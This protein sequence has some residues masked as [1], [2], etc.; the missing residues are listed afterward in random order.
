MYLSRDNG[1]NWSAVSLPAVAGK[2]LHWD[3]MKGGRGLLVFIDVQT[4]NQVTLA[5]T[6]DFGASWDLYSFPQSERLAV[7]PLAAFSNVC[8]VSDS[9]MLCTVQ[10]RLFGSSDRGRTFQPLNPPITPQ[11]LERFNLNSAWLV[12]SLSDKL[13]LT[14]DA[15]RTWSERTFPD[16]VHRVSVDAEG[17]TVVTGDGSPRS[18]FATSPGG[19]DFLP[20]LLPD[21]DYMVSIAPKQTTFVSIDETRFCLFVA[22]D[23]SGTQRVY[24]TTDGGTHW[25]WLSAD[26]H[27]MDAWPISEAEVLVIGA[28]ATLY[29]VRFP[30]DAPFTVTA[31]GH[32]TRDSLNILVAWTDPTA[33]AWMDAEIERAAGDSI[34]T[35][36]AFVTA[37][38]RFFLDRDPGV[39]DTLRYR[40]TLNSA[41]GSVRQ[42][43][44]GVRAGRG[45]YF[46]LLGLILP[47]EAKTLR[48]RHH[49]I[50]T[51]GPVVQ[52]DS[53]SEVRYA[54]SPPIDSTRWIRVHNIGKTVS[55]PSGTDEISQVRILEF[56]GED[57]RF[58][59]YYSGTASNFGYKGLDR[60]F[61]FRALNEDVIGVIQPPFPVL[62]P[63]ALLA[64]PES[65]TVRFVSSDVSIFGD[66]STFRITAVYGTG[67]TSVVGTTRSG[68]LTIHD[69][70][71]LLEQVSPVREPSR[72]INIRIVANHP[73]PFVASTIIR[74]FLPAASQVRLSVHDQLGREIAVPVDEL[75]EAG[76]HA[77]L[78]DAGSLRSGIYIGRL[79]TNAGSS[80]VMMVRL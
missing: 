57:A 60:G 56:R 38:D 1:R 35:H 68:S 55:D 59:Y 33:G 65:D 70:L 16:V 62:A 43:S 28:D 34:W 26:R 72:P 7:H 49:R 11:K 15:G 69:T 14:T 73:N 64:D 58:L 20:V 21:D 53:V 75:R 19:V 32:S 78:F 63:S 52:S 12:A 67:I 40:V 17:R 22:S 8:R 71:V 50:S 24:R 45:T 80:S 37:P 31:S 66:G 30:A 9:S 77:V 74:Y 10:N 39:E 27:V 76:E 46:D 13:G 41:S 6:D 25:S 47:H 79:L 36:V 29:N 2:R 18:V 54:F 61:E 44:N 3:W 5:W 4:V 42:Y 48:Y 23:W 51:I